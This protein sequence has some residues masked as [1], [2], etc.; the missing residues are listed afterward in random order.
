MIEAGDARDAL[1]LV[2]RDRLHP[3][4]LVTDVVTPGISG[5]E[6]AER[7]RARYPTITVLYMSGYTGGGAAVRP[8]IPQAGTAFRHT[9]FTSFS[10]A[11]KV[12]AV[13]DRP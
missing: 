3:G 11:H 8:G 1:G 2:E 13:L 6:P 5:R 10:P 9:P 12:C 4:V 7:S